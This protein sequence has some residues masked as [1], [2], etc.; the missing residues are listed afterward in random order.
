MSK[1]AGK[2]GFFHL[3]HRSNTV[4]AQTNNAY[5]ITKTSQE[6]GSSLLYIFIIFP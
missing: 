2:S 3:H 5:V 1:A 4:A 6:N